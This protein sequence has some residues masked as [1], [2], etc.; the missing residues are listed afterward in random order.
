MPGARAGPSLDHKME[1]VGHTW[2]LLSPGDVHL[3]PI[4][5]ITCNNIATVIIVGPVSVTSH[6][7]IC[8]YDTQQS[9]P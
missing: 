6:H 2:V 3:H 1:R 8:N 5:V 4:M 7:D 9:H